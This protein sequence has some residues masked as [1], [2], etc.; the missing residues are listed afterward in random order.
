[1]CM[2]KNFNEV[3]KSQLN[4]YKLK[5]FESLKHKCFDWSENANHML[6]EKQLDND[7]VDTSLGPYDSLKYLLY[8]AVPPFHP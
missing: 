3:W 6:Y 2:R 1:M 5:V 8:I 4:E 7:I